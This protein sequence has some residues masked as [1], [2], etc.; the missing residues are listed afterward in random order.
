MRPAAAERHTEAL[1]VADDRI[2][3][4]LSRRRHQRQRE[5]IRG[6]RDERAS[7]VRPL[8]HRPEIDD[9]AAIIRVLQQQPERSRERLDGEV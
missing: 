1:R 4:H 6:H 2:R 9:A 8:D 3:A 5:E 7:G